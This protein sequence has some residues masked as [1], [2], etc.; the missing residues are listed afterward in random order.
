MATS[1]EQFGPNPPYHPGMTFLPVGDLLRLAPSGAA[2]SRCLD[3]LDIAGLLDGT[4]QPAARVT[5]IAHLATCGSCRR[6]LAAAQ[7]LLADPEIRTELEK[8]RDPIRHPRRAMAA[9]LGLGALAATLLLT[10]VLPR[11]PAVDPDT[12]RDPTLTAAAAPVPLRPLGEVPAPAALVWSRV[13]GASGYRVTLFDSTGTVLFEQQLADT[14][15]ALPDSIALVPNRAYLW[16]VEARTEWDRWSASELHE[17]RIVPR[18]GPA[19]A[20]SPPEP[21]PDSGSVVTDHLRSSDELRIAFRAA[22]AAGQWEA[23]KRLADSYDGIWH[24]EYLKRELARFTS[25]SPAQ[26][27]AK[28]WGDSV[29][30]A[31]IAVYGREGPLAAIGVWR[32]AL[33]RTLALPDSSGSAALLGNIGAAFAREARLDSA[34][35]YLTRARTLA[36]AVGDFRVAANAVS[37]LAGVSE[38]RDPAA[39]REQYARAIALHQKIGDSRGLAADYNNLASL[40]RTA[41]DRD[42]A[43]RKFEAAL[44][45]NRAAGRV[46]PAATNLVNLAS[47]AAEVGAFG[48]AVADY[49]EAL[50]A[51]RRTGDSAE[52]A[53]ALEGLGELSLRRGDYPESVASFTDALAVLDRTGPAPDALR[54]RERLAV[55]LAAQGHLQQAIDLL[56]SAGEFAD[57]SALSP[58]LRAGLALAQADLAWQLNRPADAR[59]RYTRAAE[60]Y[61]RAG[62]PSG[63]AAARHGL[64]MLALNDGDTERAA[65]LLDLALQS[66]TAG[67]DLRSA[68]L[69]RAALAAVAAKA[70]DTSRATRLF[71]QAGAE[72]TRLHDPVAAAA[73][74]GEQ[75]ELH[76]NGSRIAAAESLYRAALARLGTRTVPEV[77]WSLHAGLAAARAGHGDA[78]EA[79]TEWGASIADIER[80]GSSLR[81][82][83]R[84]SGV[85]SDKWLPYQRL[86][87]LELGRGRV[88]ASFAVSEALRARELAEL[89][90]YGRVRAP[91]DTTAA[92]VEREQDLRRRVT[93]LTRALE[94][95]SPETRPLRGP[96]LVGSGLVSREALLQAQA[97][98]A[99]LRLEIQERAPRHAAL[100][101]PGTVSWPLIARKLHPDEAMLEYLLS[102]SSA[103]VFV[104]TR[105]TLVG[106]PLNVTSRDLVRRVEFARGAL[107]PRGAALDGMWRAPF[108]RLYRDLIEPVAAR[109][110]LA[111]K[112]HLIIVPHAELHYLPFAALVDT[113]GAATRFL[114]QRYQLSYT[115]SA[116]VWLALEKARSSGTGVGTLA[117]APEPDRLPGSRSEVT[118][119]GQG[120]DARVLTGG[121]ATESAFRREAPGRR[122]IH[123]ASYGVL[124]KQNPLFSYLKLS[125]DREHDG[126]L[127]AHEVFGLT[128]SADLV[129]L[130]ACQTALASGALTDLPPGDDWVGLTRAFLSAG[131]GH[132]MA[133]LW[134][135]QD[136]AT[137]TLMQ[138]FYERYRDHGDP[139][140]SLAEAQRAMLGAPETAHP[141]YWAAFEVV[142]GR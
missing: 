89:L 95:S 121:A 52:T 104:I 142:G 137:A 129:V 107:Q 27:T 26:R 24:D 90:S 122:V 77:S 9:L 125:P 69:T 31:G 36:E 35:A 16:R 49:R 105:D 101:A 15:A 96:E 34:I 117:F 4:H 42:G 8:V 99:A 43:R 126:R 29:R 82:P 14:A 94:E 88:A 62:T 17:F 33:T 111:G 18:P 75:A 55:S 53:S 7:S 133:S 80:L 30:L 71:E 12:L 98:Y 91:R 123:L 102:D 108:R 50:S 66:Q 113:D 44:D 97:A 46:A 128:L 40:Y 74:L 86:A 23:A 109:G 73:V 67:G 48:R 61:D 1:D 84:R 140:R 58:D 45:L 103:T 25:W 2:S 79:A 47:L 115:P 136:R 78:A 70:G 39:A 139:A 10:L 81:V 141:F 120:G 65:R 68:A 110:L 132:V 100:I 6:Q 72:L 127:E 64:G 28:L 11:R 135:V 51:W 37:E 41:G 119:I 87:G 138:R 21:V 93:E 19:P 22:L 32:R 63:G 92:L 106:I 124:N 13:D 130:A 131:A 56:R 116:S 118:S 134:A 3:E 85:L 76:A 59:G 60:L 20:P 38:W 83:E 54:V 57:R 112:T 5:A 114:V